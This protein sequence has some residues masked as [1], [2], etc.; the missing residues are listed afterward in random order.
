MKHE[1]ND[2]FN[3]GFKDG[4]NA[5]E[6]NNPFED[7]QLSMAYLHGYESGVNE[8]CHREQI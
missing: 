2:A 6:E 7:E 4:L 5:G 8:Y 1:V 3:L